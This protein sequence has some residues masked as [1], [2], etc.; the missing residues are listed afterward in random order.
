MHDGWCGIQH[1]CE[2]GNILLKLRLELFEE[3]RYTDLWQ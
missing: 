2:V 3:T 1:T